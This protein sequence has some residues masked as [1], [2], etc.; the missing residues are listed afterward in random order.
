MKKLVIVISIFIFVFGCISPNFEKPIESGENCN[1]QNCFENNFFKCEKSFGN[2]NP[3]KET[4]I[5]YQIID[6][7][8][9]KCE[10]YL[11][12]NKAQNL[13]EIL[14]G[15]NAK[16][17]LTFD[18]MMQ[19]QTEMNID[20]LDCSGPLYQTMKQIKELKISDDYE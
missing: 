19:L 2:L 1:N 13:P 15:L 5:Y 16:C 10:I 6:K 4:E 11:E 3:S 7:K 14:I 20:Q 8:N 17:S 18:E 12:L 9:N